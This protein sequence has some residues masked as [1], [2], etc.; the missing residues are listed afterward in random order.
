M[1]TI[2]SAIVIDFSEIDLFISHKLL[3]NYGA[4]EI[5]TFKSAVDALTFLSQAKIKFDLIIVGNNMPLINGFEFIERFREMKLNQEQGKI[6]L[7]SAFF[8]PEEMEKALKEK[9]YFALKPLEIEIIM[10]PSR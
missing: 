1:T 10:Q 5:R 8:S 3:E 4:K 7:L 2:N 6:I 9:I